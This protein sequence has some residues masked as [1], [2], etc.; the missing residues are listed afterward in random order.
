MVIQDISRGAGKYA[1]VYTDPPWEQAKGG[2]KAVRPNSSGKPLDYHTMPLADIEEFHERFLQEHTEEKHNVF[3]WCIDKYLPAAEAF[4]ARLGYKL[5]ARIIWDKLNGPAPAF[6]VRFQTEYLL[7]FYKP[8][9]IVMP[10]KER[11]GKYSTIIRE[12]STIHSKKPRAAYEMLE[13]MFP[14]AS[15]IELFARNTRDGW[16]GFGDELEVSN[17][18]NTR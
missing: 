8:G 18:T 12:G 4:V 7:W 6:T 5:H 15:K 2:K 3:M 1:I 17:G 14:D 13:D 11:R 10:R 16:D 9:K